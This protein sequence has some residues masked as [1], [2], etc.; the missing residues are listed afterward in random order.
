M[1]RKHYF[2]TLRIHCNRLVFVAP[3]RLKSSL[4]F[5]VF[6][7]PGAV[8]KQKWPF[9]AP[10]AVEKVATVAAEYTRTIPPLGPSS[11]SGPLGPDLSRASRPQGTPRGRGDESAGAHLLAVGGQGALGSSCGDGEVVACCRLCINA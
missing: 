4:F 2:P 6:D 3:L 11:S 8:T 5:D 1:I 7:L 9:H 10:F